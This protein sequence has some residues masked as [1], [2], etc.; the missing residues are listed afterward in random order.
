MPEKAR[1]AATDRSIDLV[2]I[3]II[4]ASARMIRIAVSLKM[5][6]R[7]PADPKPG[8]RVEKASTIRAMIRKRSVSRFFNKVVI[9]SSRVAGGGAHQRFRR[10]AGTVMDARRQAFLHH[11][12]P[13]RH[14]ENFR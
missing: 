10:Q 13:V 2:R 9:M 12:H 8:A 1:L 14:A 4:W 5:P 7:L 6:D 3:T 11:H